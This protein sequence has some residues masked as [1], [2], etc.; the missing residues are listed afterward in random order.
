[1]KR[2]IKDSVKH[3]CVKIINKTTTYT[4][5]DVSQNSEKR[6]SKTFEKYI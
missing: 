1:M 2:R 5:I 4:E 3:R 6:V